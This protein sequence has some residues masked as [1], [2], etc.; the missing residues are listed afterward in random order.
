MLCSKFKPL[1]DHIKKVNNDDT[2]Y[3]TNNGTYLRAH[4]HKFFELVNLNLYQMVSTKQIPHTDYESYNQTLKP[5]LS[6][7][8]NI[9]D[10]QYVQFY[11]D[12]VSELQDR[13]TAST[14][15]YLC[16]CMDILI[17]VNYVRDYADPQEFV[18][19]RLL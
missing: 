18:K 10:N 13:L 12:R 4:L 5:Y 14:Q 9:R 15:D 2:K 11:M 16:K 7:F 17:G 19:L 8:T 3:L 1:L 6:D